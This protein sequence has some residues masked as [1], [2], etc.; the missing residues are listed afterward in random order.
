[1]ESVRCENTLSV[2]AWLSS[3]SSS[4]AFSVAAKYSHSSRSRRAFAA[5]AWRPRASSDS[6]STVGG[7][8]LGIGAGG[9]LSGFAGSSSMSASLILSQTDTSSPAASR[10]GEG[11]AATGRGGVGS[12]TGRGVGGIG[13]G[14][15]GKLPGCTIDG[16]ASVVAPT[17]WAVASTLR[18]TVGVHTRKSPRTL[19]PGPTSSDSSMVC[20][21]SARRAGAT[22]KP[23]IFDTRS[24]GAG[25]AMRNSFLTLIPVIAAT[26]L[27]SR[28]GG[29]FHIP[30]S[31]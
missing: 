28:T 15:G 20:S 5:T 3:A 18:H 21:P 26:P 6:A 13:G 23:S 1:M 7:R 14:I 31:P 22:S 12:A 16:M 29:R 10:E 19:A 4:R 17:V 30:S 8:A 24:H 9:A 25:T 11:G 27:N 2:T